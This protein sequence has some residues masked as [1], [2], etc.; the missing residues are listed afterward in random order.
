MICTKG[1]LHVDALLVTP[2]LKGANAAR[3]KATEVFVF[4][5]FSGGG[6]VANPGQDPT[7]KGGGGTPPPPTD[8]KMVVQNNGFCGRWRFCFRHTAGGNHIEERL[9]D[10][11]QAR[12]S[13]TP[14]FFW[15]RSRSIP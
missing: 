3:V 11:A 10:Q 7:P 4:L 6:T 5:S 1:S 13:Y 2:T 12:A 14:P 8:P 15:G 9:L